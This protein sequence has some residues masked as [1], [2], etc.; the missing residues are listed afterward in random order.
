VP[1]ERG[2]DEIVRGL[3]AAFARRDLPAILAVCAP[4]V[5]FWPQGTGGHSGRGR[6]AP[7]RGHAGMADYLE[8]VGAVWERLEVEPRDFRVAGTGVIAFGRASGRTR[9]GEELDVPVIWVF[10]LRGDRMRFGRAVRTEA[11]AE[12]VAA[13]APQ[14][15]AAAPRP[16]ADA[17]GS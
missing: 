14:P 13:S 5:E 10:K 9:A 4:D 17:G 7:Y 1:P 15:A 16:A 8:D 11:Q 6:D 3:F 2:A 12:A